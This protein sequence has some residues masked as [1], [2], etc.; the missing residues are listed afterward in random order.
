MNDPLPNRVGNIYHHLHTTPAIVHP[1]RP[2]TCLERAGTATSNANPVRTSIAYI[3]TVDCWWILCW[4]YPC[5][6]TQHKKIRHY[7]RCDMYG[8]KGSDYKPCRGQG[9]GRFV[10]ITRR[11][12]PKNRLQKRKERES[13]TATAEQITNKKDL[14]YLPT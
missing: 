5:T 6:K 11:M 8:Q 2:I 14:P 1:N 13:T 9:G 4:S 3:T 7:Q 12:V 10:Y